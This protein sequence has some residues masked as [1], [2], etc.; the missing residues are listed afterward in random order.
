MR[1]F[2]FGRVEIVG[3][4]WMPRRK[5]VESDDERALRLRRDALRAI[6][7]AVAADDALD[8]AVKRSIDLH[9]A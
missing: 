7:D 2:R 8:A 6:E 9:G 3:R 4:V 1:L 5:T